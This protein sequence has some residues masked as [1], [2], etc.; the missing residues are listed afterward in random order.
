MKKKIKVNLKFMN[1]IL[2]IKILILKKYNK[3]WII[4]I[5]LYIFFIPKIRNII[6]FILQIIILNMLIVYQSK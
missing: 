5:I 4:N 3:L 1:K 6:F 2:A